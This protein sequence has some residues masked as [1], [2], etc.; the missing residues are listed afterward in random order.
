MLLIDSQILKAF[1]MVTLND[2]SD[3]LGRRE[4][5]HLEW[6]WDPQPH[7]IAPILSSQCFIAISAQIQY[8]RLRH[9]Q[10]QSG[11]NKT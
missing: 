8:A 6:D 4:R 9:S 5:W 2:L 7:K 11:Q 1:M 10:P 3:H